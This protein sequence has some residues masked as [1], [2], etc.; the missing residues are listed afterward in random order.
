MS[1][2]SARALRVLAKLTLL[3]LADRYPHIE[4]LR[5]VVNQVL[6]LERPRLFKRGR[7]FEFDLDVFFAEAWLGDE[8][9]KP[10]LSKVKRRIKKAC[11][12]RGHRVPSDRTIERHA[13]RWGWKTETP[14]RRTRPRPARPAPPPQEKDPETDDPSTWTYAMPS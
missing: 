5:Q 6:R 13:K 1:D 9:P 3:Q 11:I 2:L 12:E 10:S 14:Q 4:Q 8:D 7:R